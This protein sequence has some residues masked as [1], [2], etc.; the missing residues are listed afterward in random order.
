[1]I[2][3]ALYQPDIPQNTGAAIRLCA[4]LGIGLHIIEPCGFRWDEKKIKHAAMDYYDAL[5]FNRHASWDDFSDFA[6]GE[7]ARRVLLTT[8]ADMSY[9][10]FTFRE[11]DILIAGQESAGVPDDVHNACEAAIRVPMKKGLRSLNVITAS[12]MIVGEALRQRKGF[13]N[14]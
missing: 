14:D 11:N 3:L 5:S 10:C 12:A 2:S 4:C 13:A 6:G 7:N 8:K 1:M 9:A